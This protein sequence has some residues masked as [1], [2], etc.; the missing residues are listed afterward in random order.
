MTTERWV[1]WFPD[2]KMNPGIL[3]TRSPGLANDPVTGRNQGI[4]QGI[5]D[6]TK[7]WKE[8]GSA[9]WGPVSNGKVE[10]QCCLGDAGDA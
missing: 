4:R 9:R 2:G 5:T 8:E 7:S 6:G 1:V 10:G 3:T